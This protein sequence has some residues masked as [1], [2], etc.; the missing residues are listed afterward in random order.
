MRITVAVALLLGCGGGEKEITLAEVIKRDGP[1]VEPMLVQLEKIAASPL[2]EPTGTIKLSGPPLRVNSWL[3]G[4]RAATAAMEFDADL[5][6][7]GSSGGMDR[8]RTSNHGVFNDCYQVVRK[9][10]TSGGEPLPNVAEHWLKR[11]KALRYLVVVKVLE[12]EPAKTTAG[13]GRTFSGGHVAANVLVFDLSDGSYAGGVTAVAESS[14]ST[15]TPED[16]LKA[17]FYDAIG[18]AVRKQL[19]DAYF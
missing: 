7:L 16:D 4:P 10:Q 18:S 3:D 1:A 6:N 9:V 19:P 12:F 14:E 17:N 13:E 8:L 11:C 15:K 5:K 2:P